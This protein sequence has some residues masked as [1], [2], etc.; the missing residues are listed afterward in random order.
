[1]KS[2]RAFAAIKIIFLIVAVATIPVALFRFHQIQSLDTPFKPLL[3]VLLIALTLYDIALIYYTAT[4][5]QAQFRWFDFSLRQCLSLAGALL[6]A[7]FV[8]MPV[9]THLMKNVLIARAAA[10]LIQESPESM[11]RVHR[12]RMREQLRFL[13]ATAPFYNLNPFYTDPARK[14]F[15][16]RYILSDPKPGTLTTQTCKA[17]ELS[18]KSFGLE[19]YPTLVAQGGRTFG[20]CADLRGDQTS[21]L[22]DYLAEV[23]QLIGPNPLAGLS[24]LDNATRDGASPALHAALV[25]FI[26]TQEGPAMHDR[27]EK[28][29]NYRG[30]GPRET[31]QVRAWWTR[32]FTS[33]CSALGVA[34]S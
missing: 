13:S 15:Y 30:W 19:K 5:R 26:V 6:I 2:P 22:A 17:I 34:A 12:E 28:M 11:A 10:T 33:T 29:R 27:C 23:T 7:G 3:D 24:A 20:R 21:A 14:T 8:D 1:M 32:T 4:L 9:M 18:V 31:A 25:H 16:N